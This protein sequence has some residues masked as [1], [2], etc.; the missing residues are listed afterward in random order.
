MVSEEINHLEDVRRI[1]TAVGQRKQGAWTTQEGAKYISVTW[2]DL[3]H[4]EPQ[5]LSFL[6]KQSTTFYQH[7]STFMLGG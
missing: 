2:G 5:K 6:I 1:A 4:I 3:K 7:H